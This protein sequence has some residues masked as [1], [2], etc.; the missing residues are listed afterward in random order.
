MDTRNKTL[1]AAR[2]RK[3]DEWYTRVPDVELELQ[4]YDLRGK[5]IYMPC[6]ADTSAFWVYLHT[7]FAELGLRAIVATHYNMNNDPG[8]YYTGGT[9]ADTSVLRYFL[10]RATA[11]CVMTTMNY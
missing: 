6:D 1:K 5:T 4:H 8:I 9:D 11:I 7:H 3:D 10:Y 2:K